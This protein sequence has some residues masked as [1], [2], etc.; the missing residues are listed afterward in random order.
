MHVSDVKILSA[1]RGQVMHIHSTKSNYLPPVLIAVILLQRMTN[2]CN[3]SPSTVDAHVSFSLHVPFSVL[4][5]I[6]VLFYVRS[7]QCGF[8]LFS[9]GQLW[10]PRCSPIQNVDLA[11]SRADCKWRTEMFVVSILSGEVRDVHDPREYP[12]SP[13]TL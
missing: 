2:V 13:V 4:I 1:I 7:I 11:F 9:L 5:D 8:I 3:Y 10:F 12:A 6:F